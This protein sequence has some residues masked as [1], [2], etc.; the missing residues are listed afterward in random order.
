MIVAVVNADDFGLSVSINAGIRDAYEHGILRSAS[1]MANGEGFDD[2]VSRVK[3]HPGLGVGIHLS[4]VGERPI[5]PAHKLRGLI[6]SEGRLPPSYADFARGYLSRR[7][8]PREVHR[9]MEAQIVHVLRAGIRPT[10]LDSH[11]HVHLMP[12]VFDLTLDLA[13]AYKIRVV[14]IPHDR[15]VF[16]PAL[17]SGRGVQLG[18]LVFLSA[19]ARSKIRRRGLQCAAFFHGLVDS[20]RL[21]TQVLCA[22]LS[23][24]GH[25]VH[26]IMCHPGFETPALRHHYAWGYTWESEA[27]ALRSAAVKKLVERRGIRLRN[28]AEAW[29]N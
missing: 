18:V 11:Q 9:E 21:D 15:A 29:R 4:L 3:E 1:L 8:T 2:A 27:V 17:A 14:R 25:G 28:F 7:F 16:S 10:H 24:L 5:A 12:G 20:G 6:D 19:L 26:E 23:R 22:I 13:E